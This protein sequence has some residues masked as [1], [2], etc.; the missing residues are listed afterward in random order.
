MMTRLRRVARDFMAEM[1]FNNGV[2]LVF[3]AD[4]GRVPGC[5]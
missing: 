2:K 4:R 3:A 5:V 1:S